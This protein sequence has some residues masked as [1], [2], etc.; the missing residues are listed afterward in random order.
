[1]LASGLACSY[2]ISAVLKPLGRQND[3]Y[4]QIRK[5]YVNVYINIG[6]N[7]KTKQSIIFIDQFLKQQYLYLL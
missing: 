2:K 1:M 5:P 6:N 7:H 3:N 4:D